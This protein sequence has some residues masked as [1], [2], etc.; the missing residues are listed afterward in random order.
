MRCPN[1][2]SGCGGPGANATCPFCVGLSRNPM[3]GMPMP[4][5]RSATVNQDRSAQEPRHA[6]QA[7]NTGPAHITAFLQDIRRCTN[8]FT[9]SRSSLRNLLTHLD[10]T[11]RNPVR[12]TSLQNAKAYCKKPNDRRLAKYDP[13]LRALVNVWGT[14]RRYQTEVINQPAPAV[15]RNAF[16]KHQATWTGLTVTDIP[17]KNWNGV[18]P[19]YQ[20]IQGFSDVDKVKGSAIAWTEIKTLCGAANVE[21]RHEYWLKLGSMA[22]KPQR[23]GNRARYVRCFSCAAIAAYTLVNDEQFNSDD[24]AVVA[25]PAFDHY[26]TVVGDLSKIRGKF[27]GG[28]KAIDLWQGNMNG[29]LVSDLQGFTYT[30]GMKIICEFPKAERA[31]H[32]AL[33]L[34]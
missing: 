14:D 17:V 13:A 18:G 26:F 29:Q 2:I 33:N 34:T 22:V 10:N 11:K 9:R 30:Q 31:Q 28:A 8:K 27:Y 21:S 25:S 12:F 1:K 6:P 7:V 15:H 5:G 19:R 24:I 16:S 32:A 3:M 20:N 4:S 23:S